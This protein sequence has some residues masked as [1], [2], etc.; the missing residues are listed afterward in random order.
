MEKNNDEDFESKECLSA[1]EKLK[2]MLNPNGTD[3]YR[4]QSQLQIES[5]KNGVL[6]SGVAILVLLLAG[7]ILSG[8]F[9]PSPQEQEL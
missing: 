1:E 9:S 5:I 3:H 8:I 6:M 4:Q 2:L 7:A